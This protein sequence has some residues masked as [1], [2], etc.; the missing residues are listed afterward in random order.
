M[1]RRNLGIYLRKMVKAI[2]LLLLT[3]IGSI[4]E[5]LEHGDKASENV[6]ASK[7]IRVVKC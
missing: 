2:K 6:V 4:V 7:E 1:T 5:R 3:V